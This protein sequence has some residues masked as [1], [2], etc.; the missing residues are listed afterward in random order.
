MDMNMLMSLLNQFWGIK[1][2]LLQ[3]W[4]NPA[5]LQNVNFNDPYALNDL[6]SK[7]MPG[8]LKTRPDIASQIKQQAQTFAPEKWA[9]IIE[10]I[11]N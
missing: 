8:L 9:E 2:K 4:V 7:I 3:L 10:M 5:D 1:Q 6:A 11:G